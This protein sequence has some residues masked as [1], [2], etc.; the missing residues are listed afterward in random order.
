M[1]FQ[2]ERSVIIIIKLSQLQPQLDAS[3]GQ[4]RK[5]NGAIMDVVGKALDIADAASPVLG[6]LPG[7]NIATKV[8]SFLKKA[9]DGNHDDWFGGYYCGGVTPNEFLRTT[10]YEFNGSKNL[11]Y[12]AVASFA[13]ISETMNFN[14]KIKEEQFPALLAHIR[15][16]TNN[17]LIENTEL[18]YHAFA[19]ASY[20][21]ALYYSVSKYL[22]LVAEYPQNIRQ[23]ESVL[24]PCEPGTISTLK[25]IADALADYLES[26]VRLP[27]AYNRYLHW[28]YSKVF[29][30]DASEKAGLILYDPKDIFLYDETRG[31]AYSV[32]AENDH[33]YV[34]DAYHVNHVYEGGFIEHL[35]ETIRTLKTYIGGCG[36][37]MADIKLA[38]NSSVIRKPCERDFDSKEYNMRINRTDAATPNREGLLKILIDSH[39]NMNAAIQGVT[40]NTAEVSSIGN[41]LVSF[42][43]V[44]APFISDVPIIAMDGAGSY[45]INGYRFGNY[46]ELTGDALQHSVQV[47]SGSNPI[48]PQ[49][50]YG[51]IGAIAKEYADEEVLDDHVIFR[52]AEQRQAILYTMGSIS[53]QLHYNSACIT[54][55]GADPALVESFMTG[56][57]GY[58]S[59]Y[60]TN[61]QLAAIHRTCLR[62]LFRGDYKFSLAEDK[63]NVVE[64][65]KELVTEVVTP[66]K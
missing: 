54:I 29:L 11:V 57:L 64:E 32:L 51:I 55:K 1:L 53:L 8:I 17:V 33:E 19:Y 63:E 24:V 14:M 62:N 12:D 52:L 5:S 46:A 44:T 4:V 50:P 13:M 58:D 7:G 25:G 2:K 48:P 27:D 39:L 30:S 61:T 59:A 34:V 65:T 20:L 56:P 16:K 23:I 10:R 9:K 31:E 18:Y 35:E 60:I 49:T 42:D 37:A 38:F 26:T 45:V 6:F 36:R 3:L 41:G 15:N 66:D 22:K 28:R 40:S 21:T 47:T 43:D